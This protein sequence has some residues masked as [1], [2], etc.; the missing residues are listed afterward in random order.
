MNGYSRFYSLMIN[1]ANE[2][3]RIA[4]SLQWIHEVA[5]DCR[6]STLQIVEWRDTHH[7]YLYLLLASTHLLFICEFPLKAKNGKHHILHDRKD[8]RFLDKM[9]IFANFPSVMIFFFPNRVCSSLYFEVHMATVLACVSNS[10]HVK[11]LMKNK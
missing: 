1:M 7:W 6:L 5:K 8:L 2:D 4:E 9:V 3:L 10:S 11:T